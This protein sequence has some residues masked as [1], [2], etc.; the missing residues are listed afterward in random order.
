MA[1]QPI[2]SAA[3]VQPGIRFKPSGQD[4]VSHYLRPRSVNEP[5]TSDIIIDAD[6]LTYNPWELVTG[7][8]HYKTSGK[9]E[10]IFSS[11][12]NG[13]E[14]EKIGLKRTLVFYRGRTAVGQNT[15]WVM[16][17]YSLVEAGL[18]PYRV[19]KPSGSKVPVMVDP[20]GTWVVCHI[21]K[22][23][24]YT[25]QGTTQVHNNVEGGQ[26]PFYNFL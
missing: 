10:P 12:I 23:R 8:G 7:D 14:T 16:K 25:Q 17:E 5:L 3:T 1:S 20:D 18:K 21:Y 15:E 4:I 19:M 24:K 6:I 22:K 13:G 2:V 11:S 9:V 26:V